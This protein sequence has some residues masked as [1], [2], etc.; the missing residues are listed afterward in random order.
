MAADRE[1]SK[2][3]T[4]HQQDVAS[5][6][7]IPQTCN[8]KV[9]TRNVELSSRQVSRAAMRYLD[10]KDKPQ[11]MGKYVTTT[12]RGKQSLATC[13]GSSTTS[14]TTMTTTTANNK[15]T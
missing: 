9:T 14:T 4:R 1:Q 5:K 12:C 8:V 13:N 3:K 2:Q 10:Q 6:D 15:Y 7:L 11:D